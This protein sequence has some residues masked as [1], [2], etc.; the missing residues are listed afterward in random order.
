MPEAKKAPAKK[1]AIKKAEL[2]TPAKKENLDMHSMFSWKY[3]YANWKR[4]TSIARVR[5]YEKGEWKIIVNWRDVAEYFAPVSHMIEVIKSP[6]KLTWSDK[7]FNITVKVQWWWMFSQA[8]AVRHWIAKA[9]IVSNETLKPTLKKEGQLTRDSR[10]KER[11]K[12][13]LKRARKAPTWVKR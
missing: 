3:Y 9:L 1:S 6:L 4:K 2:K 12:P 10:V 11:K 7:W 8:D 13:G 5:A